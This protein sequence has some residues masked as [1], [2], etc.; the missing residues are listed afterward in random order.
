MA[1]VRD[2]PI[3][4]MLTI[5]ANFQK[6]NVW[7]SSQGGYYYLVLIKYLLLYTIYFFYWYLFY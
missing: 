6:K 2:P 7:D 1:V 5:S 4:I 3:S